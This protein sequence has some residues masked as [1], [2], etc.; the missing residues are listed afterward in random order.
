MLNS[1]RDILWIIWNNFITYCSPF[2]GSQQKIFIFFLT[3][4]F[5]SFFTLSSTSLPILF[6]LLHFNYSFLLCY[7][8]E[9]RFNIDMLT[10][11]KESCHS[12]LVFLTFAIIILVDVICHIKFIILKVVLESI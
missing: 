3:I 9:A 2:L 7:C 8:S 12:F 10:I 1:N 11:P 6:T 5:F 4:N